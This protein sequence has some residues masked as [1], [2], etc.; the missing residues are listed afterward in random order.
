[1]LLA[2]GSSSA[3]FVGQVLVLVLM[4]P[5]LVIVLAGLVL[6]LVALIIVLVLVL[7]GPVLVNITEQL[8]RFTV[9][10]LQLTCS[11]RARSAGVSV[12]TERSLSTAD[13]VLVLNLRAVTP[14]FLVISGGSSTIH[15]S[16]FLTSDA[17]SDTSWQ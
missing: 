9:D 3:P 4:C 10:A 6:V 8:R 13:V 1:M 2:T 7:V 14:K 5:V 17:G 16:L 15:S 12:Q 11:L